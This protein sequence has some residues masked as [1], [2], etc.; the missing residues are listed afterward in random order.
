[1]STPKPSTGEW[2]ILRA[3]WTLGEPA[4]VR[5]VNETLGAGTG[6]TTTLKLMQ[7]MGEKGLLRR[8]EAGKAHLYAPAVR[9]KDL[10][11]DAAEDLLD[12]V[13]GG[14]AA[15]LMQRALSRRRPK[16]AELAELRALLDQFE[17]SR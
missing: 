4:T 7:I 8:D 1:M 17:R 14:S 13:F 2:E 16:K 10:E 9:Q 15:A 6:Y 3:L 11:A 12:R 5:Q